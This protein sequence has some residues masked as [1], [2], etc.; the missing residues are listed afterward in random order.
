MT[1]CPILPML[2]EQAGIAF[3]NAHPALVEHAG[4]ARIKRAFH[5]AMRYN[6]IQQICEQEFLINADEQAGLYYHFSQGRWTCSCPDY[7]TTQRQSDIDIGICAH[8]FAVRFWLDGQA[9][10]TQLQNAYD[11]T[12]AYLDH[13]EN[14]A[15]PQSDDEQATMI[16]RLKVPGAPALEVSA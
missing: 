13:G 12:F 1:H 2:I 7:R 3:C 6:D 16:A 11:A 10:S 14:E 5:I 9:A 15:E 4:P 8:A